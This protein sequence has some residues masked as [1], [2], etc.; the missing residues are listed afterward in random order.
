MPQKFCALHDLEQNGSDIPKIWELKIGQIVLEPSVF[1]Y[2]NE[3]KM[4]FKF[5]QLSI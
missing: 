2:P 1:G 3:Y 5:I 4:V